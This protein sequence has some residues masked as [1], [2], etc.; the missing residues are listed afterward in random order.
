MS[1]NLHNIHILKGDNMITRSE[2]NCLVPLHLKKY[3]SFL[4]TIRNIEIFIL[5]KL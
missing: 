3:F 2:D 5:W 1:K 4:S